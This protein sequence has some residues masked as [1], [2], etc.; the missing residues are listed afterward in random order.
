MRG[1][2]RFSWKREFNVSDQLPG[3]E[4]EIRDKVFTIE[5]SEPLLLGGGKYNVE[6][7]VDLDK[8]TDWTVGDYQD[9]DTCILKSDPKNRRVQ[10][11]LDPDHTA[12]PYSSKQKLNQWGNWAQV[13]VDKRCGL[14][15][16]NAR[17]KETAY[18]LIDALAKLLFDGK[19]DSV[20]LLK[21]N[22]EKQIVTIND[23]MEGNLN[24]PGKT[25]RCVVKMSLVPDTKNQCVNF[26][27]TEYTVIRHY[28]KSEWDTQT[29]NRVIATYQGDP[30]VFFD[31][32]KAKL[33]G[34]TDTFYQVVSVE[35]NDYM[36][37]FTFDAK[38]AEE[39]AL[40]AKEKKTKQEKWLADNRRV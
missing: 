18:T 31:S 4:P 12:V 34:L 32:L 24:K 3:E 27:V 40:K 28:D 6:L 33:G 15:K 1:G 30:K 16:K 5:I 8:Y 17:H 38:I 36:G 13:V 2:A 23:V 14:D 37:I 35:G 29:A 10:N 11:Y 25:P 19:I 22:D 7:T 39:A 20:N 9:G 26:N 21:R